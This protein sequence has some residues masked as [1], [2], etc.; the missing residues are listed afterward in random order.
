M[1]GDYAIPLNTRQSFG[2]MRQKKSL[3]RCPAPFARIPDKG[4]P[5]PAFSQP[6]PK[7]LS[8]FDSRDR[9]H[10]RLKEPHRYFASLLHPGHSSDQRETNIYKGVRPE[11]HLRIQESPNG[12]CFT[13]TFEDQFLYQKR[14]F[15]L[16]IDRKEEAP[17]ASQ[18]ELWKISP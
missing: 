15:P 10:N 18:Q 12:N 5:S 16:V 8:Q 14:H 6:A 3:L 13:T 17:L 7:Q 11:S 4:E 1:N 9:N 2:P